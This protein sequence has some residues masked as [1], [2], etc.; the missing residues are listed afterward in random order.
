MRRD[1]I[2]R[3]RRMV[4]LFTVGL[5]ALAGTATAAQQDRAGLRPLIAALHVHSTTS[6]GTLDL[7]QL[8]ERA[9]RL[10]I[11][12]VILSDNFALRFEYGLPPLRA[13]L[14]KTMTIPSLTAR[15]V[16]GFLRD[17]AA[18][19]ARHPQVML[20]PGVEV[21]P[22]YYWTGSLLDRNLTMHN[23]QRNLLV[24]GLREDKDYAAL[25]LS[26]NPASYRYG[27]EGLWSVAPGLLFVPAGWLWHRSIRS[28]TTRRKAGGVILAMTGALL[29]LNA[30]PFSRPVFSSYDEALGYRPYQ[31]VIDAVQA[32]KGLTI[33][34]LPEA[35][36]FN[37]HSFGPL[38]VVTVRTEP[39]P[40]ALLSTTGYTGF[41]GLYQDQRHAHEPGGTWDYAIDQYLDGSRASYP[42]LFGEIA[43]HTPGEAGIE[44]N[45]VLNVLRVHEW[46]PEGVLDAMR[47][48][49]LYAVGQYP[50]GVELRLDE[51]RV[52]TQDGTRSAHTGE[53]LS[54]RA[55]TNPA[56]HVSVS[57]T[58]GRAYPIIVT[59]IRKGQVVS[60]VNGRTPL[61]HRFSDTHNAG[62]APFYYRVAVHGS[63]DILS[64]P[65]FV[66]PR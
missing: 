44:L 54:L 40:E 35:R 47:A 55:P 52:S 7:D 46:S 63:G 33:W 23:S 49:R 65:I 56:L 5:A 66:D 24:L 29:L 11:D 53:R 39:H 57:A 37:T 26:G 13:S 41:G 22:H 30:W 25:P 59:I 32:G 50:S 4:A 1:R 6:T 19:Q 14:R 28:F 45:Q 62:D 2:G 34:S 15:R 21:V 36:D 27:W 8:A 42:I 20:I 61:R 31:A 58:D 12:A 10:G 18:A 51:F 9:E 60:R 17:V 3:R 38:G 48:G 64:N 43:F 16:G